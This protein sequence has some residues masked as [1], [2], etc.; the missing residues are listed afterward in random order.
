MMKNFVKALCAALFLTLS[1]TANA[2]SKDDCCKKKAECCKPAAAC[3]KKHSEATAQK[4][5]DCCKP[6]AKCCK[7][8]SKCCDKSVA[9]QDKQADM[10]TARK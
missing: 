9:K 5:D 7:E 10:S 3:C 1:F 8:E 2:Q 4:T 6:K